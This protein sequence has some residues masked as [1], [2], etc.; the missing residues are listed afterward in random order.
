M[1]NTKRRRSHQ[2]SPKTTSRRSCTHPE[3]PIKQRSVLT[4]RSI[5]ATSLMVT[6][7][8]EEYGEGRSVFLIV[9]PLF[10]V[11]GLITFTYSQMQRGN[12]MVVMVRFE[13]EKALEA[14]ERFKV[15][16]LYT[17]PPVV[18][19]LV[20]QVAVVKRFDT[21]SLVEI[22]SGAAPLGKD[23]MEECCRVFPKTKVLQVIK[24]ITVYCLICEKKKVNIASV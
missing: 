8:Q 17:A 18:L 19:A 13:V 1:Q 21:T 14:I 20:K 3:Q 7:D 16:H 24:F 4:H 9:V 5:I 6:S 22:G 23:V 12:A 15:T 2:P 11:M 10:H